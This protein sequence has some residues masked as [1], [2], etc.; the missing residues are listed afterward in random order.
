MVV[1]AFSPLGQGQSYAKM[2]H[3]DIS[4]PKDDV[5]SNIAQGHGVTQAQVGLT[6]LIHLF[7]I[8]VQVVLRWGVR[9]RCSVIPK[10]ENEGRIRENLD[11]FSF[12]LSEQDMEEIEGIDR[13]L[14]LNDP[15]Y[16]CP[17]NF[18][19]QCPIWD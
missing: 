16:F 10:S 1:T 4:A 3:G 14:R 6:D 12:S 17:R 15:G 5:I 2:G 7:G 9:R 13:N 19:T 18:N 8:C 11:L